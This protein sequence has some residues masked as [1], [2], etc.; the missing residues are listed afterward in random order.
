MSHW[1]YFCYFWTFNWVYRIMRWHANFGTQWKQSHCMNG[2]RDQEK[3]QRQVQAET[4]REELGSIQENSLDFHVVSLPNWLIRSQWSH[5]FFESEDPS[6]L[7]GTTPST[8]TLYSD[9]ATRAQRLQS[10]VLLAVPWSF[11]PLPPHSTILLPLTFLQILSFRLK[12]IVPEISSVN[13][14]VLFLS[15]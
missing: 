4:K 12:D 14:S 9:S 13:K 1:F 2:K 5:S 3:L 11:A 6:W 15:T 10:I 7:P 8:M